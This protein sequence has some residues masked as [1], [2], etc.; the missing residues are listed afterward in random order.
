MTG[1]SRV[2]AVSCGVGVLLGLVGIGSQ[3]LWFDEGASVAYAHLDPASLAAALQKSDVFFGLYYT[4][5]HGW[6]ALFGESESSV[7][8]LSV[9]CGAASVGTIAWAASLLGGRTA[10]AYATIL[11]VA[12]AFVFAV[13][14]EARPYSMLILVSS[15]EAV[16]FLRAARRPTRRRWVVFAAAGIIGAYVHLF[17]LLSIVA[18]GF[19]SALRRRDL[20]N[21]GL[22][23]ALA[24]IAAAASPIVLIAARYGEINGWIQRPGPGVAVRLM[25]EF[26]GSWPS[27]V[28][29]AVVV[30]AAFFTASR[31]KPVLR[32]GAVGF[33][34]AWLCVPLAIAYL[35]SLAKP[36]F[37]DKYLVEALPALIIAVALALKALSRPTVA[38]AL[39]AW[40]LLSIPALRSEYGTGIED[41]RDAASYVFANAS[42]GDAVSIYPQNGSIVYAYYRRR[43][44]EAGPPMIFPRRTPFPFDT[45]ADAGAG[46][47]P[48]TASDYRRLWLILDP[49]A[50]NPEGTPGAARFLATIPHRFHRAGRKCYRRITVLRFDAA[51]SPKT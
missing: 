6:I 31:K 28:L 38:A 10:A 35:A 47:V 45:H 14:R 51:R 41:W 44:G 27:F 50:E 12:D 23:L 46:T 3:S 7:R 26:A 8:L 42:P 32:H 21:S 19:W 9:L 4:L 13:S 36:V 48:A 15:L 5:L 1:A 37:V 49:L 22:P 33:L 2:V 11:A 18:F 40:V 24:V 39:G 16:A 20:W 43:L 25:A 17:A 34:A 29:A 30:M